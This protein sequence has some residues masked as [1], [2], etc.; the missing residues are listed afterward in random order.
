MVLEYSALQKLT[1]LIITYNR[2]KYLKR[3]LRYWSK[4]NVKVLIL[5]GSSKEF[6][7]PCLNFENIKYIY[8]P[9]SLYDR[10]LGSVNYIDTEFMILACDDEFYLPSA[11][12]SCI[13]FLTADESFSSCGG[14][15]VGFL[16]K[17]N[18]ILGVRQ[19]PKLRGLCLDHES[20]IDRI[21][22]HF[23]SYVPAHI[24][25]V[26]RNNE[27]KKISSTIFQK[28]YNFFASFELQVEFLVMVSGKSKII[29]ELM[30]MRNNE[31]PHNSIEVETKIERWW[32]DKKNNDEKNAFLQ[33]MKTIAIELS[34]EKNFKY[35][36]DIIS[37]LFEVYNTKKL[38]NIKKS[39]F[40]KVLSLLPNK[41]K[42]KIRFIRKWYYIKIN[43]NKS[44]KNLKSLD[45]EIHILE[46]EG[47]LINHDELNK[48]SSI[49][50]D[51]NNDKNIY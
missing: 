29:P 33:T 7:D 44:D 40:R 5:D 26:I 24:Y 49:I 18:K 20:S 23:S 22:K 32:Y 4:Y 42:E 27:W 39:F 35:N 46:K 9:R 38:K 31:V 50:I 3:T 15:A 51:S 11:L 19:Y 36:E 48:I 14:R 21:T 47:V 12:C 2:H 6:E 10:I 41:L 30:W 37:K 34:K 28:K 45:E 16:T 1:I 25:S 13:N 43:T 17:K 8:D